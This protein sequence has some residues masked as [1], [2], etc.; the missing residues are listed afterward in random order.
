LADSGTNYKKQFKE[1][2]TSLNASVNDQNNNSYSITNLNQQSQMSNEAVLDLSGFPI[3][4]QET[5][6]IQLAYA[7]PQQVVHSYTNPMQNIQGTANGSVS[8]HNPGQ[9]VRS[10][11]NPYHATHQYPYQPTMI[12][13][14]HIHPAA[15]YAPNMMH[16]PPYYQT[17]PPAPAPPHGSAPGAGPYYIFPHTG[18]QMPAPYHPPTYQ[19]AMIPVKSQSSNSI[20]QNTNGNSNSPSTSTST[21][22]LSSNASTNTNNSSNLNQQFSNMSLS[23]QS[24][25][26]TSHS[27]PVNQVKHKHSKTFIKFA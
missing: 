15:A 17:L 6:Q 27:L 5:Q 11:A 13:H 2:G 12:P 18:H 25:I 14:T 4:M 16:P 7:G 9:Y 20:E 26:Q 19:P 22:P 21:A 3:Q 8:I 10:T 23:N 24:V 1:N